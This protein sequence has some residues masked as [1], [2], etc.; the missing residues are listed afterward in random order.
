MYVKYAGNIRPGISTTTGIANSVICYQLLDNSRVIAQDKKKV[1]L[2][3]ASVSVSMGLPTF[4][5]LTF[6]HPTVNHGHLITFN[7]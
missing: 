5:H 7:H 1:L 4:N 6:N 3:T 2:L